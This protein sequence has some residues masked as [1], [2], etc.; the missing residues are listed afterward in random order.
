MA[1][2]LSST[3]SQG[4]RSSLNSRSSVME[5]GAEKNAVSLLDQKEADWPVMAT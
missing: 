4:F 1:L 5:M 3:D 2:S